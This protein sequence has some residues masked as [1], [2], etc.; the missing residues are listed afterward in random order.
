MQAEKD[1]YGPFVADAMKG[2]GRANASAARRFSPLLRPL[3]GGDGGSVRSDRRHR[4]RRQRGAGSCI[5]GKPPRAARP[6]LYSTLII[7]GGPGRRSIP[8]QRST[9][10][11]P[12]TARATRRPRTALQTL[13][14]ARLAADGTPLRM[15][16]ITP[17]GRRTTHASRP[18]A[19]DQRRLAEPPRTDRPRRSRP[20]RGSVAN[21]EIE[22]QRI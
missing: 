13:F 16:P 6:D 20:G 1:K 2:G 22:I 7:Y 17:T 19:A 9:C 5:D 14:D 3:P 4:L 21:L 15:T 18:V 10:R 11:S 12:P 8:T